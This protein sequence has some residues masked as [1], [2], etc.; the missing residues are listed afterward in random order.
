MLKKIMMISIHG[1]PAADIGS[2]EQGGQPIYINDICKL[3]SENYEIDIFTRKKDKNEEEILEIFP[4]V[5]VV[6]IQAGPVKFI[7]KEEIYLYL[8]EF[9]MNMVRWIKKNKKKYLLIHSHYWD[10]AS[11][12]LKS[13]DYFEIPVVHNCHSLG[14]VKYEVIG[15]TKT[16]FADMRLLEEKLIL[17]YSNAITA[18]TPQEIKNILNL[19]N[20]VGENIKLIYAGINENL[21][22][23]IEKN[24]AI[25]KVNKKVTLNSRNTILFVGRINKEKGLRILIKAIGKIKKE[26]NQ[27]LKL[28]IVG[29]DIS[30]TRHSKIENKEKKYLKKIIEQLQ[31]S[32]NV[33]FLGPI[34]RDQLPYYYSIADIC[35]V[36]SLYESFGLVAV[37]AMACATP[38]IASKVGGLAHTVED[39]FSGLHFEAENFKDLAE[40]IIQL[41]TDPEKI[42]IMGINARTRVSENFGLKKTVQQIKELYKFLLMTP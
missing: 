14:R 5:N 29:G 26:F 40:K 13:K 42:N 36:P 23:P 22:R 1:D 8:N 12:A 41:I 2:E 11:I 38:V 7:S 30:E 33:H 39:E 9:F 4:K 10:S 25:K 35:V 19:Y 15:K 18:S 32:N 34:A 16:P 17:K 21:F 3:L 24:T 37:E 28:L 20:V 6:R 27:E 31:L